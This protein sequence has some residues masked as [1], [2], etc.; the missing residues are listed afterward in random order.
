MDHRL[1]P[2][3][4]RAS[5]CSVFIFACLL[6]PQ[7]AVA[8]PPDLPEDPDVDVAAMA[9][10]P[11]GV[12]Q[13]MPSRVSASA[14]NLRLRNTLVVGS[15]AA[16]VTAYGLSKWW[17]TGFGGG[18]KTTNEGW[19]GRNTEFGGADKLGHLYFNYGT[20][21]LLTPLFVEAGNSHEASVR[22]AAWTAL[23][24]FTGVEVA[25]GFSRRWKFSAQDAAMNLAG[26]AL[27]VVLETHP[28]LDTIFDFRVAYRPSKDSG[29]NPF[30]DYSGQKYLLVVKA[31]GFA[32]LRTKPLLRYLE[33]GLGYGARGFDPGGER[34]RDMYVG[35]SLNLSR[36]LADG[37]YEGRMHSTP[38][39]RGTDRLFELVQFPSIG[40]AQRRLD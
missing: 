28:E 27:G 23:G 3:A 26:A 17:K 6:A 16:L 29:F 14:P 9:A 15:G 19:F 37:W 20:V 33:F 31:D 24:I 7:A 32:R 12:A 1:G 35:V 18:F 39:Q 34:R 21:R 22:L 10:A 5:L 4:A 11:P 30:G 40:Y 36:L 25:D 13:D 38:F 2:I 8:G